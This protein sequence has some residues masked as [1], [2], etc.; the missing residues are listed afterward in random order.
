M[1]GCKDAALFVLPASNVPLHVTL[2]GNAIIM[3]EERTHGRQLN[4]MNAQTFRKRNLFN[5][6]QYFVLSKYGINQR[7]S[8]FDH[9][10][11]LCRIERH[12]PTI[13]FNRF[14]W[15]VAIE[16][17]TNPASSGKGFRP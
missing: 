9:R 1:L 6:D 17:A 2:M 10:Y 16:V 12:Q 3:P 7:Y 5:S 4:F 14:F 11:V 8:I 15:V 13:V